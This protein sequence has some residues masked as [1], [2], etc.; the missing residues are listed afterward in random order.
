LDARNSA[1]LDANL[2][3]V[4][5][6]VPN[7]VL[8]DPQVGDY[9]R[10]IEAGDYELLASATCYQSQS[11][12]V[13]VI[14]DTVAVHDFL[15]DPLPD[16]SPS[17]KTVSIDH[18]LPGDIVEYHLHLENTCLSNP[19][20]VTDTLPT[21]VTWTGYITATQGTPVFDAGRILWQGEVA[22]DQPVTITYS[23]SLNQ[24][25]A[26]GTSIFNLAEIND[27]VNN[28]ITRTVQLN[29]DNAAPSLPA[30]PSPIDASANQPITTTLT[31]M[32]SSD[33]NCDAL[34]YDLAFGTSPT[35]GIVAPGLTTP[36]YDPG[37]LSPG[38]TYYWQVIVHDGLTQ[39][40]GP[41]WSFTTTTALQRIFLPLTVR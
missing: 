7:T 10:V 36:L 39:T 11:A 24:C 30:S 27:S 9:H 28:P 35:P 5:R 31:W 41:I 21:Q 13:S 22:L 33:L 12:Q 18:A 16:F 20:L 6:D 40:I 3:L 4:G 23:V 2:T 8:T 26:A 17:F 1:P 29:V 19:A 34:S 15:L 25:L 32:P 38:S 14:S 37:I